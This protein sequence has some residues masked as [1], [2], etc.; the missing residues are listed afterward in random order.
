MNDTSTAGSGQARRRQ[1]KSATAA[2]PSEEAAPKVTLDPMDAALEP[3]AHGVGAEAARR[4]LLKHERL[5]EAQTS[6]L[7]RQ[8]WR[9]FIITALG[10][11]ILAIGALFVWDAS[12]AR[13]VV[14]EAFAVPPDMA[15][16]GLTG[17]VLAAQMLDRLTGMQAQTESLRAASTYANDWG[18]DIAVEIPSTGVSIGDLRRYLREWL[19]DQTRLSGEVFRLTD[20]RIAV[21]TRVGARPATRAEGAEA[22]LDVLIQQGA[23][24]IYAETQ[25]YRHAVWLNREGRDEEAIAAYHRMSLGA[26]L[27][28]RVWGYY[29][30]AIYSEDP[31][32]QERLFRTVLRLQPNFV[33]A[34]VGL[35]L[36]DTVHG[37]EERAF[38]G[39]ADVLNNSAEARRQTGPGRAEAL[40]NLA[41]SARAAMAG[42]MGRAAA[43]AETQIGLPTS[44]QNVAQAQLN[45]AVAHALA[46]DLSAARRVLLEHG[47]VTPE[48]M[49][50]RLALLGPE[51]EVESAFAGAIGDH[52]AERDRLIAL[53]DSIEAFEGSRYPA[54]SD[55]TI[56]TRA[57]LATA[58]A[59]LGQIAEARETIALT[60]LDCAPCVRARG[61]VEAYAGNARGA[62]HWL[63]ESVRITPSLPAA[64]TT[65][66]EAYL[67]RRDP[68]RA[69]DQAR[70]AVEKGPNWADPR[71]L[72]GDALMMR[73]DPREAVRRYRDAVRLAPNWG[74]LH[75][76]LGRAQAAAGEGEAARES[77][78][79][80]A[81]L[82][83]NAK[84]RAATEA[85]LRP[86]A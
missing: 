68:A 70:L 3:Q 77:F 5:I 6:Q 85:L 67:V 13:G 4:V 53:L 10:V 79:R 26:D 81:R 46:R 7:G 58:Y 45:A 40:L 9:D 47:I 48:A 8:R 55:P 12:R 20:G 32:E 17:P 64:H 2:A 54:R 78:R 28:D 19:G 73:G 49:A 65:W 62:D 75:L 33:P 42:D 61:L 71:K 63:S 14:V 57:A 15:E 23:E 11:C 18:G 22:E 44:A 76:A 21:T 66:A 80:A 34:M 43:L 24:A 59:R 36:A 37:R 16:R 1:R 74:G 83:L 51:S 27:N 25:P 82:D 52:A 84:D 72:W 86:A 60:A 29:G 31:D 41:D 69:I 35:D 30:L 56:L 39:L 38:H 50:E